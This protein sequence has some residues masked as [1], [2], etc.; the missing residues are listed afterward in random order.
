MHTQKMLFR[1]CVRPRSYHAIC[2]TNSKRFACSAEQNARLWSHFAAPSPR[3]FSPPRSPAALSPASS[4]AID[5]LYSGIPVARNSCCCCSFS[6]A[7]ATA[8]VCP[9]CAASSSRSSSGHSRSWRGS[10]PACRVHGSGSRFAPRIAAALASP[11]LALT[12][13]ALDDTTC[14]RTVTE[15][16]LAFAGGSTPISGARA[17]K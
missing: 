10:T 6:R 7:A 5:M 9:A 2:F 3:V 14:R 16:V 15:S 13:R 1:G 4:R 12:A 17:G 11:E 8:S